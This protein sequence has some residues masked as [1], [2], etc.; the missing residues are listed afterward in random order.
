M[1]LSWTDFKAFVS[2]R[3]LSIQWVVA[4]DNY[5]LKAYDSY[6]SF[7]CM[8][9]KDPVLSSETVDFEA[10]FKASGNVKVSSNVSV[11]SA[12]PFGAKSLIISGVLKKFYARNTGVQ[13]A[14]SSGS[15]LL[16]YTIGYP[17]VKIIGIECIG[18][19][20]L[21]TAEIKVYDNSSGTYSGVPNVLL[22]QFGYTLN[23]AKDFYRRES[24]FE[25]DLYSGM[26]LKFTYVS[27]S[28]KTIGVNFIMN[29]VKS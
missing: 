25:A 22:N 16:E 3:S 28:A 17:W 27:V 21:D 11:Q 6:F 9:P 13:Y 20:S 18:A 10:N 24:P 1:E 4:G 12:A 26:V 5:F 8:I 2:S 29:E 7:D 23:M 14:L 15:N 19:E